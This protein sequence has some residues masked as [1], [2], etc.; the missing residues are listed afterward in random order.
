MI[1]PLWLLLA[2]MVVVLGGIL[3]L[4]LHPFLALILGALVVA[5]LT[6]SASLRQFAQSQ[7]YSAAQTE[8]LV[9]QT[10]GQR[11]ARS[12]ASVSSTA[13]PPSGSCGPS[14]GSRARKARRVPS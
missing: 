14:C 2:G 11:V 6:S 5:S 9:H 10:V 7:K 13:G 3:V 4:R 8:A 1:D 12:S